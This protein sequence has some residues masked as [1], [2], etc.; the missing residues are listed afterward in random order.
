MKLKALVY[1]IAAAAALWLAVGFT[2]A[3]HA[4]AADAKRHA[5]W[6]AQ[7]SSSATCSDDY[8]DGRGR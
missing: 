1:A 5:V 2:R 7:Y 3:G 6:C 8:D 4:D